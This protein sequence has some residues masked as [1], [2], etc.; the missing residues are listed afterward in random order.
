M[1][2]YKD[3]CELVLDNDNT[4]LQLLHAQNASHWP[5]TSGSIEADPR[6]DPE[7]SEDIRVCI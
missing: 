4:G 1:F 2:N 5:R 7:I 6:H 3:A